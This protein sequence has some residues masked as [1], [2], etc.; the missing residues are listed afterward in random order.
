MASRP[1]EL[2]LSAVEFVDNAFVHRIHKCADT[3]RLRGALLPNFDPS[4]SAGRAERGAIVDFIK[5]PG[6]GG[7]RL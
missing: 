2:D 5:C 6:A 3:R 1:A 4:V 7:F